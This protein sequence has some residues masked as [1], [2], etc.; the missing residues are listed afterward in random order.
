MYFK[1]LL[2]LLTWR[3]LFLV[4]SI[5][6][7]VCLLCLDEHLFISEGK[8]EMGLKCGYGP[9]HFLS[10]STITCSL[11]QTGVMN[12]MSMLMAFF[13]FFF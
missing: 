1:Y 5:W 13:F 2:Y 4:L 9:I 6:C 11:T 8:L 10:D 3:V 12:N 7:S